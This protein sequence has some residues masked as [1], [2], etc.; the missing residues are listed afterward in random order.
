MKTIGQKPDNIT[1]IEL[2]KI[3]ISKNNVRKNLEAGNE[4]SSIEDLA[5][6]INKQGL[7]S[8]R[9]RNV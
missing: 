6:C 3:K 7:L 8:A 2:S 4:D 9:A 5:K 1:K